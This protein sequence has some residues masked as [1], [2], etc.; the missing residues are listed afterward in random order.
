MECI[1]DKDTI[2][3][4]Y[5]FSMREIYN[6]YKDMLKVLKEMVNFLHMHILQEYGRNNS[7]MY[8]FLRIQGWGFAIYVLLLNQEEINLKGWKEV[9]IYYFVFFNWIVIN[10]ENI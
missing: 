2:H 8:V 10:Y 5:N 9:S 7:T 3:I 1:S 4:P 6:L